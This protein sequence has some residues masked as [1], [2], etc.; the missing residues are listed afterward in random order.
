MV[1]CSNTGLHSAIFHGS[2]RVSLTSDSSP[3]RFLTLPSHFTIHCPIL[4][5]N[6]GAVKTQE[7]IGQT[8]Q[9]GV[10]K[11]KS[12]QN[13]D[14]RIVGGWGGGRGVHARLHCTYKHS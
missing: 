2:M 13:F 14:V 12:Q 7:V 6:E 4:Q 11:N 3:E 10:W 1:L 5:P 8:F 9:R